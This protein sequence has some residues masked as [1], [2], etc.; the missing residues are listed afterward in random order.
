ML[1]LAN[2][3]LSQSASLYGENALLC[4]LWMEMIG[5]EERQSEMVS[6]YFRGG[7]T[8]QVKQSLQQLDFL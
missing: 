4:A 5:N 1:D 6:K 2:V 7:N 8:W 3:A